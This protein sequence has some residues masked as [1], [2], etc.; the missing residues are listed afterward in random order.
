MV[1]VL[2]APRET[3][4]AV[5]AE[6]RWAGVL[7]VTMAIVIGATFV[8]LSTEVGQ[9]ALI[10]QQIG[11]M[12]SFGFQLNDEQYAQMERQVGYSPYFSAA[13]QLFFIPIVDLVIAGIALG[14]FGAILGGDATFTQVFAVVAHAGVVTAVQTLFSFPIQYVNENLSSPSN[15][16]VFLP[17]LE[18]T[19]FAARLL[20]S[21]DLFI[22][23]WIL[24][25]AIGFGVLYKRRTAPIMIAL[26]SLYVCLAIVVAA[27]R[28]ALA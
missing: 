2:T 24:S 11:A 8:F 26:L 17:F 15:L 18:E 19:S 4:A 1:G 10:D 9:T 21:I 13:G 22:T 28:S 25:L 3:Y 6:P 12:E 5:A 27:V 23:W 14:I 20:G 7:M 16:A